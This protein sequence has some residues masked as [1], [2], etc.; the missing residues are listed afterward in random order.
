ML[1]PGGPGHH[2][3]LVT[4]SVKS[5]AVC[6]MGLG[7]REDQA[8][9]KTSLLLFL[10]AVENA[11]NN[12]TSPV[13]PPSLGWTLEFDHIPEVFYFSSSLP[14]PRALLIIAL[15][16]LSFGASSYSLSFSAIGSVDPTFPKQNF[17]S[18]PH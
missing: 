10:S 18:F 6:Y 7:A 15:P 14:I 1:G 17:F 4:A 16:P 3:A 13:C 12:H 2:P 11:Y 5:T 9:C 8:H